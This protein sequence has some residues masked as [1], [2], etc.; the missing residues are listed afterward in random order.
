[1]NH[2]AGTPGKSVL[3]DAHVQGR[4]PGRGS[5]SGN[6]PP[7]GTKVS[8]HGQV[9]EVH[10]APHPQAYHHHHH[11]P[12]TTQ[13]PYS[14]QPHSGY[15]P[16]DKQKPGHHFLAKHAAVEQ[17]QRNS[18]P[19]HRAPQTHQPFSKQKWRDPRNTAVQKGGL[20]V[21]EKPPLPPRT[22]EPKVKSNLYHDRDPPAAPTVAYQGPLSERL[23]NEPSSGKMLIWERFRDHAGSAPLT[24]LPST[25]PLSS[26]QETTTQDEMS[27]DASTT[28]GSYVL[29]LDDVRRREL[30]VGGR[31]S[32]V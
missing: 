11:H 16:K 22:T 1:M 26:V 30:V 29:D 14:G 28:S 18:N 21:S 15:Y 24:Q 19:G 8:Q 10:H 12:S 6:R 32:F 23:A 25:R 20:S 27:D 4:T 7:T 9:P 17:P 2:H 3:E 31:D 13:K 5:R